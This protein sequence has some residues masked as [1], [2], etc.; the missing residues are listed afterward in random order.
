[1]YNGQMIF[2]ALNLEI[3]TISL[4]LEK[5]TIS[6]GDN[7]LLVLSVKF[8]DLKP[9]SFWRLAAISVAQVLRCVKQILNTL[10]P[11]LSS[12]WIS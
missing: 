4:N 2:K 7:V 11:L 9:D 12:M 5:E 10:G 6:C 3:E 8:G 1:M